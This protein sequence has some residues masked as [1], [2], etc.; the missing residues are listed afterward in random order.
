[1]MRRWL[2]PA[3]LSG[4]VV[5]LLLLLARPDAQ[6]RAQQAPPATTTDQKLDAILKQLDR[7]N[8]R[9][10]ALERG[11]RPRPSAIGP[12]VP[13]VPRARLARRAFAA[14]LSTIPDDLDK[15]TPH[16]V[17]FNGC[18]P[19]GDAA[20]SNGTSD[21]DLNFLKNRDDA[22]D[23]WLAVDFDAVLN[24]AFPQAVGKRKRAD[25]SAGEGDAVRKYEGLPICVVCYF[26]WARDEKE[27]SCNC[28]GHDK[29]MFDI[30]TWLLK[31]APEIDGNRPPDRSQAVVAEVTP[32]LKPDHPK[33]N[34]NAIRN[35]ARN[36]TKV[37][38]SGWL[39]LDQ[40]H[41]EQIT[42]STSQDPTRGTLW[43]I[44]PIMDIEVMKNGQ[45][46]PLDEQ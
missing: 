2:T 45:W 17:A 37:R 41:S 43:E 10:D 1:M 36:G 32:R 16:V 35:L 13:N 26:G 12:A 24:L 4:G 21:P 33:W 9:L 38:V 28:H 44:H 46:M 30:H 42:G 23:T 15:P 11:N 19:Q 3:V 20:N 14:A 22:A 5:G 7:I 8:Q 25:W 29:S 27:E 34:Q 40:E 31:D 18:G 39:M 6:S